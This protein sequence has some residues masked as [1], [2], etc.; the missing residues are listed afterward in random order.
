MSKTK[1]KMALW[2]PEQA[3]STWHTI[4]TKQMKK[5]FFWLGC[6]LSLLF[7]LQSNVQQLEIWSQFPLSSGFSS[8]CRQLKTDHSFS[9]DFLYREKQ[10]A[11]KSGL[12]ARSPSAL[13]WSCCTERRWHR[14]PQCK[15]LFEIIKAKSI[16]LWQVTETQKWEEVVWM[17][18]E[19]STKFGF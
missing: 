12:P 15:G 2:R 4:E 7:V 11:Y 19:V 9:G 1:K 3:Y 13:I 5:N 16:V 14:G 6:F 18:R 8:D 17:V 10:A